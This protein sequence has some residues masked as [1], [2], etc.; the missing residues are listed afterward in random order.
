MAIFKRNHLFQTIILGI[1][2]S[3]RGCN[4]L[5]ALEGKNSTSSIP[6]FLQVC[7]ESLF[8]V[9]CFFI[10]LGPTCLNNLFFLMRNL[11]FDEKTP[12]LLIGCQTTLLAV[13][14][15][16]PIRWFFLFLGFTRWLCPTVTIQVPALHTQGVSPKQQPCLHSATNLRFEKVML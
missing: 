10:F 4:S 13:R 2:V 5:K 9:A 12:G 1:H 11:T 6:G 14:R 3:F 8:F 7:H 15:F 16:D